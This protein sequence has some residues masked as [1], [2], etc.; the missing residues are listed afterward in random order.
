LIVSH[1]INSYTDRGNLVVDLVAY[2]WL[3]FDRFTDVAPLLLI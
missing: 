1:V 3:F 2:D